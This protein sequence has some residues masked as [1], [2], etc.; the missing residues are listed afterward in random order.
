[1]V[2][3]AASLTSIPLIN[4]HGLLFSHSWTT[5]L[6]S[7][8]PFPHPQ[9]LPLS[10]PK[11]APPPQQHLRHR[12]TPIPVPSMSFVPDKGKGIFIHANLKL[13]KFSLVSNISKYFQFSVINIF[14]LHQNYPHIFW[15]TYVTRLCNFH[16]ILCITALQI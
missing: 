2:I 13:H 7:K 1:M 9:K 3:H 10:A 15:Q 11:W 6:T 5:A 8:L 16:F 4:A 14:W 12:M